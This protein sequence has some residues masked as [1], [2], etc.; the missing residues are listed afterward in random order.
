[1]EAAARLPFLLSRVF[2][3]AGPVFARWKDRIKGL[4]DELAALALAMRRPDVPWY[5]QA[6][7]VLVIAYALSPI[8]LIPDFIPVVGL[9]DDLLLVPL[10]ILA[11]RALVPTGVLAECRGEV[12]K[13][14]PRPRTGWIAA[15]VI[16]AI[17][18][19]VLG[20]VLHWL[21]SPSGWLRSPSS[22]R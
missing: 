1:M 16:V 19:T 21:F 13:G 8:D 11:V 17:W 18:A 3:G 2:L 4:N 5:A 14:V 12:A 6:L 10:G 7:G 15:A 20:A 22:T 9:L